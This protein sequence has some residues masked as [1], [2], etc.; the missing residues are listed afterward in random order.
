MRVEDEHLDVLQNIEFFIVAAYRDHPEIRDYA[1]MRVLDALVDSYRAEALGRGPRS[2]QLSPVEAQIFEHSRQVC[3]FWLGRT[4]LG[5]SPPLPP[6]EVKSLE[7]ILACIK[8]IQKSVDR[9]NKS[10]GQRGYLAFVS[11]FTP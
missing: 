9:W 10:G 8:R 3:Q 4:G 6:S 11:E 7:Q 1:V 5:T 2:A